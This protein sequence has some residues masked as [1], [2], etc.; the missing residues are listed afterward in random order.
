MCKDIHHYFLVPFF[1]IMIVIK[2]RITIKNGFFQTEERGRKVLH[3]GDFLQDSKIATEP[4]ISSYPSQYSLVQ[5][6]G[7]CVCTVLPIHPEKGFIQH[8]GIIILTSLAVL[9][10]AASCHR[11]KAPGVCVGT[12]SPEPRNGGLIGP[13]SI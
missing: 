11:C 5:H 2:L 4:Y 8:L 9:L 1:T 10:P 13:I 12:R 6:S 3:F 7:T